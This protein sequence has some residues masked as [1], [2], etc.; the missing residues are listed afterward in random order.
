[1][2]DGRIAEDFKLSSGTFVSVG[3]LRARVISEGAPYVQDAV[4]T[5]LD[6]HAIGLMI[7]PRMDN[8]LALSTL[9]DGTPAAEVLASAA[10]RAFFG[11]LLEQLNANASGSS[12]RVERMLLLSEPPSID[13]REQTDKGSI[14]Q[15]AVLQ[16]RAALVDALYDGTDSNVIVAA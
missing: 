10:V 1:M 7:F 14:N 8:C 9:P 16:R 4:V 13:A 3:P 2:F 5:G 6:R 12:T 15:A 11:R